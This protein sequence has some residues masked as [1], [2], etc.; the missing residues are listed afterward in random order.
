MARWKEHF[1]ILLNVDCDSSGQICGKAQ[2]ILLGSE[3]DQV[4]LT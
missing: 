3:G 2:G 4:N 1:D